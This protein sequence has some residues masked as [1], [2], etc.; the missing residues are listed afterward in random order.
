MVMTDEDVDLDEVEKFAEVLFQF[1]Y[2]THTERECIILARKLTVN[3]YHHIPKPYEYIKTR[4][5]YERAV[6]FVTKLGSEADKLMSDLFK[7]NDK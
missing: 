3:G 5:E 6:Q 1:L 2:N 7:R 4:K